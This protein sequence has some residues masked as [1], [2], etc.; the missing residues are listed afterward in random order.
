[1]GNPYVTLIHPYCYLTCHPQTFAIKYVYFKWTGRSSASAEI[2]DKLE[3][4]RID[5]HSQTTTIHSPGASAPV[6]TRTAVNAGDVSETQRVGTT[7]ASTRELSKRRVGDMDKFDGGIMDLNATY[8]YIEV[9]VDI[10]KVKKTK[11]VVRITNEKAE[12]IKKFENYFLN[13]LYGDRG[14]LLSVAVLGLSQ[15]AVQQLK[16]FLAA[17]GNKNA[18]V[19]L[20]APPPELGTLI[21]EV[22]AAGVV[23]CDGMHR[24][25]A[26]CKEKVLEAMK[27]LP[28]AVYLYIRRDGNR[29]TEVDVIDIGTTLNQSASSVVIMDRKDT[30]NSMTSCMRS[31]ISCEESIIER[32]DEETQKMLRK[33]REAKL[34]VD[35]STVVQ[36]LDWKCYNPDLRSY[37]QRRK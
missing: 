29:M 36:F 30:L 2:E 5:N 26:L 1:M 9:S 19:N 10:R 15:A 11:E 18:L 8:E 28:I 33:L 22:A 17:P 24:A 21:A 3:A 23:F 25:V 12:V 6:S 34:K 20:H 27:C 13:N 32:E 7:M 35:L 37:S 31:Y 16:E 14:Q 4:L